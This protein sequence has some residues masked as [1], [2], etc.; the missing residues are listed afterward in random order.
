VNECTAQMADTVE[1]VRVWYCMTD[2]TYATYSVP[3]VG[4]ALCQHSAAFLFAQVHM[5]FVI[6]CFSV[7]LNISATNRMMLMKLDFVG[8]F[9]CTSKITNLIDLTRIKSTLREYINIMGQ[10]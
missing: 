5:E 6:V 1:L 8:F 9:E 7:T 3:C 4:L 2:I 10:V